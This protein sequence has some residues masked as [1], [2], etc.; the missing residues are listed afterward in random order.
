MINGGQKNNNQ[1]KSAEFLGF[2]GKQSQKWSIHTKKLLSI[3]SFCTIQI[4]AGFFVCVGLFLQ[5]KKY[6]Q[7]SYF[8]VKLLVMS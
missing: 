5:I 4:L 7:V 1:K 3:R 2:Q 6:K 8:V